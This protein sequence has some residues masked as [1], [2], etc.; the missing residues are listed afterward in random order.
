MHI[1]PLGLNFTTAGLAAKK[2]WIVFAQALHDIV[3][4]FTAVQKLAGRPGLEPG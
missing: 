4:N 2:S 3:G 1:F